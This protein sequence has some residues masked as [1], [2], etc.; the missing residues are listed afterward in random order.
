M[1]FTASC[2]IRFL[3]IVGEHADKLFTQ[4]LLAQWKDEIDTILLGHLLW[5]FDRA[6]RMGQGFWGRSY[7][8]KGKLKERHVFQLDQ[9]SYP[10]V[11]LAEHLEFKTLDPVG[12]RKWGHSIDEILQVILPKKAPGKFIFE[13]SKTPGDDQVC[14]RYHFSSRVFRTG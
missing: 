13:T 3:C 5:I 8:A 2:Q 6:E 14:M 9:Q 10:L 1:G 4:E 7:L 11:E 12:A